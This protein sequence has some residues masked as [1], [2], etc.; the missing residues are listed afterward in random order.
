MTR[1]HILLSLAL[2]APLALGG[3]SDD[4]GGDETDNHEGIETEANLTYAGGPVVFDKEGATRTIDIQTNLNPVSADCGGAAWL[5]AKVNLSSG[6]TTQ[7]ELTAT[8]YKVVNQATDYDPRTTTL[9]LTAEGKTLEIAVSQRPNDL[10]RPTHMAYVQSTSGHQPYQATWT[11]SE[12]SVQFLTNATDQYAVQTPAWIERLTERRQNVATDPDLIDILKGDLDESAENLS[13]ANKVTAEHF[14]ILPNFDLRSDGPRKGEITFTLGAET[15]TSYIEQEQTGY[16]F[17]SSG[18]RRQAKELLGSLGAG[19]TMT[20]AWTSASQSQIE[21]GLFRRVK[22]DLL[23]DFVRLPCPFIASEG[24]PVDPGMLS[25]MV[26]AARAA[27]E[28]GL[29]AIITLEDD[30]WI[31]NHMT[32]ADTARI[33]AAYDD[34][35][36]QVA[37]ACNGEPAADGSYPQAF[38]DQL[39]FEAFDNLNIPAASASSIRPLYKRLTEHFVAS[40]RG[41]GANNMLRTLLFP[42]Y[43]FDNDVQI[44]MPGN[45]PATTSEDISAGKGCLAASFQFFKPMRYAKTFHQQGYATYGEKKLWGKLYESNA[46][47]ENA[48]SDGFKEEA[49]AAFFQEARRKFLRIPMLLS[50]FGSVKHYVTEQGLEAQSEAYYANYVALQAAKQGIPACVYDNGELHVGDFGLIDRTKTD[51]ATMAEPRVQYLQGIQ[52]GVRQEEMKFGDDASA[53][54]PQDGQQ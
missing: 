16:D 26:R 41:T 35:W 42:G 13:L 28:A 2:A 25:G 51:P 5:K 6:Q 49:V 21:G 11:G 1:T 3:C 50:A 47:C 30:G 12:F 10:L 45:D 29:A 19:W 48:A 44:E 15:F 8:P 52:K 46:D 7:V 4:D 53:D 27:N 54:E 14:R 20:A 17:V 31:A 36:T 18:M 43:D 24:S 39:L 33:Y 37:R 38:D 34:I 23:F 32:A 40:V 9:T 22:D